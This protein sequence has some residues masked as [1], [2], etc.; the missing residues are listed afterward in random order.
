M[1]SQPVLEPATSAPADR[2]PDVIRTEL[3]ERES[4]IRHQWELLRTEQVQLLRDREAFEQE[5]KDAAA[6]AAQRGKSDGGEGY[7]KEIEYLT[8]IKPKQAK[9]FLRQK[10]D[11]DVVDILMTIERRNFLRC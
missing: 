4:E 6:I 10:K 5:K 11:A 2:P 8:S 3:S 7:K 9:D 1:T